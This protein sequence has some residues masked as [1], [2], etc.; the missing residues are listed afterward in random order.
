MFYNVS[1]AIYYVLVIRNGWREFQL[2]KIRWMLQWFPVGL[3]LGLALCAIPSYDQLEYGCHLLPPPDGELWP[4]LTFVVLPLTISIVAISASMLAVYL[5][6]KQRTSASR[7]WTFGI[8]QASAL[9]QG[10]FWQCLF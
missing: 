6:V 10:V 9:E 8:G 4:V 5:K 1:L 2:R 7:K 3:G